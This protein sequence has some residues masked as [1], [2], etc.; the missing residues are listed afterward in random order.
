M[1][2]LRRTGYAKRLWEAWKDFEKENGR[3]TGTALAALIDGRLDYRFDDS[4]LTKILKGK[5]RATVDEHYAFAAELRID[6][7][8]LAGKDAR[9][10]FPVEQDEPL[11][12]KTAQQKRKGR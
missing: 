1:A 10:H 11:P 5:R 4:K 3:L 8:V 9:H 7:N 6:P 2:E 12:A